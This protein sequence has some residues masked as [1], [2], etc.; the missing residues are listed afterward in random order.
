MLSTVWTYLVYIAKTFD[1]YLQS[2]QGH[3]L[4]FHFLIFLT[5]EFNDLSS[6]K[7]F[8][9]TV[10][11]FGPRCSKESVP[12]LTVLTLRDIN[13]FSEGYLM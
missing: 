11:I 5:N 7:S 8:G 9:N 13:L 10:Q 2:L 12:Y 4:G 1:K 3:F 6:F